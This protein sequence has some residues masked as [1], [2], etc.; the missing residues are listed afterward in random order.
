M[1]LAK[2]NQPEFEYDIH[3]LIKAF[4]PEQNVSATAEEKEYEEAIIWRI[5]INYAQDKIDIVLREAVQS[6][7][8]EFQEGIDTN[9]NEVCFCEKMT[10]Q[11]AVDFADRKETKN[12]LKQ[13]LYDMLARYSGKELPWGTLTGIRPTKIPMKLLEEG[14]NREEIEQYMKDTYFAS[15]EKIG[16]SID[17]AEREL[18]LLQKIDYENGYS[19]YIGIPFC[20]TTCLY[21]SFT[22]YP[23]SA[24]RS[25]VDAYLDALEKEIQFV[26]VKFYHKKLNSIYIGGG[27][28]TT[29]EPHQLDRLIRKI[30]CSFDL[31]HCVEFTVEAGRPDSITREKL[32][33]LHK[34]G[35]DRISINPQTMKDETLKLIGRHHTVEQ[36]IES[37]KLAREVGFDNI[38]MDLILGLPG[39]TLEDV[40]NTMEQVKKL[41][42]DN[43]TV[44]SL[45]LKRAA[46]LNICKDEYKD[47]EMVN[48]QEHMDLVYSYCKE[49]GLRP[50]YLYRQKS[51]AGNLENVGYAKSGKAGVYNI[52]IM[53]EKQTIMALGAGATTKFVFKP[54]ED[55]DLDMRM[56]RV[57]NVKDVKNYLERVDEMIERKIKKMNEIG[58]KA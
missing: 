45:A 31:S 13:H 49:L 50:Y 27:T 2:L 47:F 40:R 12:Q 14:K 26:S 25:Q 7:D 36:T 17:I 44:H 16:L 10:E 53:E 5:D 48:T 30:K 37:Y 35:I 33:V 56:E 29:L 3:S 28:P 51:M 9:E 21:C 46:R 54:E 6:V 58:W 20:P 57:E 4:Y 55:S 11:F 24:W 15:D 18:K 39:E 1:I 32:E 42:P 34:W 38:N 52:L 41:D 43:L 22:S 8:C 19:L 23:L